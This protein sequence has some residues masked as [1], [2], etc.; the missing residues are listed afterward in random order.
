[1]IRPQI[2]I[3]TITYNNLV[4]L[5]NTVKSVISQDSYE[6]IEYIIIDGASTDGTVE[7]LK[8][9]P[10]SIK[11][12]SER[13]RGISD[14]FNKGLK[15][16][17]GD[18]ILMLNSGDFF[19]NN[20]VIKEVINDWKENTVDLLSYKVIVDDK[21]T[22]PQVDAPLNVWNYCDLPHQGTFVSKK[23]YDE[24]GGYSEEFR[25]RM[26][27]HFFARCK[28]KGFS[29]RYIPK[30][31]T[32]YEPGGVSM[33]KENRKIF[34]TEGMAVKLKYSIPVTLKDFVK[35]LLYLIK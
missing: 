16:A 13:D 35:F 17:T 14:A 27:L 24:I 5:N 11:W 23:V 9:L 6:K 22:L 21:T 34:W 31:I 18:A 3:I 2:S 30:P 25:I 15:I 19:I 20:N 28:S 10:E 29:F 32:H 7:Y 4:G 33:K 1:M 12:I 8:T 26:D